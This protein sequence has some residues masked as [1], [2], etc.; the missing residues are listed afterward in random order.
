MAMDWCGEL[1]VSTES[2]KSSLFFTDVDVLQG[3]TFVFHI[4]L[5][6]SVKQVGVYSMIKEQ[7]IDSI[8]S[9]E[10]REKAYKLVNAIMKRELCLI[11]LDGLDEWTGPGDH[12]NLPTLA[13]DHSKCV[14]LFSTRPW[15]LAVVNIPHSEIYKSVQLE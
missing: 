7:I 8:Y 10:D 6:N 13:V 9:L 15:K 4:T 1:H 12:H 14:M 3:Y 5:R 2:G 11:V